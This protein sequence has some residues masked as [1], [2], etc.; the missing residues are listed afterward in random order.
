MHET[1]LT[2]PNQ[3]A[4]IGRAN[5]KQKLHRLMR[6]HGAVHGVVKGA[7]HEAARGV[8]HATS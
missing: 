7:V 3:L 2:P 1:H 8:V 4:Q 5:R 6:L